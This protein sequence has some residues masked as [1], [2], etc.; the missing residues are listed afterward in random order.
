MNQPT[1][2]QADCTTEKF[3]VYLKLLIW[4]VI[5]IQLQE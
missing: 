4:K 3:N 5:K 1:P 2:S